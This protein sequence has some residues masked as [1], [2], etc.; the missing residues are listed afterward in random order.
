MYVPKTLTTT[1]P[2]PAVGIGTFSTESGVPFDFR[3]R[4]RWV[5]ILREVF[6]SPTT[7]LQ[8]MFS[9]SKDKL[10]RESYFK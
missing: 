8:L 5:D 7:V 1:E 2:G 3:T 9:T 4:A 6:F 10:D